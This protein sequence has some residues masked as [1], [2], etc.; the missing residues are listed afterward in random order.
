MKEKQREKRER[1]RETERRGEKECLKKK[2]IKLP[3]SIL[4]MDLSL[5][6]LFSV[7]FISTICF[8]YVYFERLF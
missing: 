8:E 5:S 3:G 2:A 1:E 4:Q 7:I 6:L